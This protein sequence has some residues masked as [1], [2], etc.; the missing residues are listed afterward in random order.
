M[1]S[2]SSALA[3]AQALA[4]VRGPVAG[5]SGVATP[6]NLKVLSEKIPLA[7]GIL[8]VAEFIRFGIVPKGARVIPS[9]SLLSSNHTATVAGK[10]VFVPVDGTGTNQEITTVVANLEA[11]ETTSIPDVADDLTVA[12]DSWVQFQ[13]TADTTIATVAKDFR[14]RLAYAI[15]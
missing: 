14:L 12:E 7:V 10:L 8:L 4:L 5:S 1:P 9:L 13:P 15:P 3:T 11:T 6:S 2:Q